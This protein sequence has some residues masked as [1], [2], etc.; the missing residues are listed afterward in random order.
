MLEVQQSNSEAPLDLAEVRPVQIATDCSSCL[1]AASMA[2]NTAVS[3][4]VQPVAACRSPYD[5]QRALHTVHGQSIPYALPGFHL[6]TLFS[7]ILKA[8]RYLESACAFCAQSC[9]Q[10]LHSSCLSQFAPLPC[11]A[12]CAPQ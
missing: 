1:E 10:S 2:A 6:H 8:A 5:H 9:C 7:Y 11:C 4:Q 12:C 3:M